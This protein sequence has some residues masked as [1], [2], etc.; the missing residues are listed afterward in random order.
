[1]IPGNL[2]GSSTPFGICR[3]T[4]IV[5]HVDPYLVPST[6]NVLVSHESSNAAYNF[7][8]DFIPISLTIFLSD[9][10]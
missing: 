6:T 9:F 1:M 10:E 8:Y 4:L 5:F 7:A 3:K 2:L